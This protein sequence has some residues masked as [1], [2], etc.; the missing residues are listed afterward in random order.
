MKYQWSHNCK[1]CGKEIY[2]TPQWVYKRDGNY[3]C[4][5]K[6]Y[7]SCRKIKPQKVIVLP[8][9][10]DTIEIIRII[11]CPWYKG[12]VGVVEFYDAFGQ[13]H[14]TWGDWVILPDK[15]IYKIIGENHD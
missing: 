6:C 14:G 3:Y 4:S 2:P 7:N 15:D 10:G 11:G 1:K 12:K 8:E 5:W 13:I 9:I